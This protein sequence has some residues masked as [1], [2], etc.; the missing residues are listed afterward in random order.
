MRRRRSRQVNTRPTRPSG[1]TS[2]RCPN[3]PPTRS[4]QDHVLLNGGACLTVGNGSAKGKSFYYFAED[5]YDR[6]AFWAGDI[7]LW[8][9]NNTQQTPLSNCTGSIACHPSS[10]SACTLSRCMCAS[11]NLQHAR[12]HRPVGSLHLYADR[13]ADPER[14][15]TLRP[16]CMAL[17]G[18]A[19]RAQHPAG[20]GEIAGMPGH[21]HNQCTRA[22]GDQGEKI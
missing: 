15:N 13:V 11:T 18:E 7:G 12:V 8:I 21:R 5:Q 4:S 3:E 16:R 9:P 19:N 6:Q 20:Q 17:A 22:D 1:P 10:G 14:P 2:P